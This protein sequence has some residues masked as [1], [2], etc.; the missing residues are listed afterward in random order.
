MG[1]L[2]L[3]ATASIIWSAIRPS[4][5]L[6]SSRMPI[7][8]VTLSSVMKSPMTVDSREQQAP[9]SKLGTYLI[10]DP[11]GTVVERADL[12]TRTGRQVAAMV[13]GARDSDEGHGNG[14]AI[15]E[16]DPFVT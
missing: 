6:S 2:S 8:L 10:A 14:L 11:K 5:I 16:N 4:L 12:C 9:I 3:D 13:A 7:G 1:H 15:D